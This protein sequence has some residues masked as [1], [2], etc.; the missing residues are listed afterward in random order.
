MT[1]PICYC[2]EKLVPYSE[3]FIWV[4]DLGLQRGYGIFDFLRVT[5][6]VPLFCDDHIDRFYHSAAE[7]LLPVKQTKEE[8]TTIIRELV[9]INALPYSGIKIL[10]TGGYSADGYSIASPNLLIIQQV[11]APPP[12]TIFLPGYKLFTYEHQRQLPEVKTTDYLMAIRLQPWLKEKRGD[13]ILY[14]QKGRVTECPRSNF[15]IVT[16]NNTLVTP[17]KNILRGVTRK[18]IFTIAS[19]IGIN[20]EEKDI[21]IEDIQNAKEAF[22][23]SSTKRIIPV[24][25]VDTKQFAPFTTDSITEKL[26]N[27]FCEWEKTAIKNHI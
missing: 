16:Q 19:S 18:Q 24:M 25:Q 22:I 17:G 12:T 23:T 2:N 14:H 7:M 1:T 10:L 13:D 4:N 20:I 27:A 8:L 11:I 9:R 15:F 21:S 26:F 5:E 6:N 3:A